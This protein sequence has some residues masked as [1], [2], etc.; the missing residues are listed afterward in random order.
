MIVLCALVLFS[1]FILA[2]SIGRYSINFVTVIKVIVSRIIPIQSDWDKMTEAV[3]FSLRFPRS[4]AAVL[5]GSAMALSGATYQ[6]I[7][8]NPMV[9][10]DLLGVTSGASVGAAIAIL[11]DATGAVIELSA[12]ICGVLT[13]FITTTISRLLHNEKATILVLS[14]VI[15]SS[16]MSSIMSI[17]K[18]VADTDT[19]LAEITYWMMGSFASITLSDILLAL[20]FFIIPSALILIMSFRLNVMALGEGEAKSLG[21]DTVKTRN[22]FIASSTLLTA[23]SVCLAGTIGWVGLV[24]PHVSRLI[25]GADNRKVLPLSMLLGSAFMLF[26]D[27]LSRSI[28]SSELKL[29]IL[30]GIIGAPFF[31]FIIFRQNRSIE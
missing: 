18:Y 11:F 23:A 20:P 8:L 29:G 5:I 14:G 2:L 12:F 22:I 27:I 6:S 1:V 4:L 28:T 19:K 31:F 3:I 9:S 25:V 16:F 24:I 26:V 7:F 17:L 10:P 21:L 30:T 15:V 13:V